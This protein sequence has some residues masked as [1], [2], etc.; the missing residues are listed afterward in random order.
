MDDN[1]YFFEQTYKLNQAL[2]DI[3]KGIGLELKAVEPIEEVKERILLRFRE[4][5]KYQPKGE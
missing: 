4:L 5:E 3:V 1:E 2:M